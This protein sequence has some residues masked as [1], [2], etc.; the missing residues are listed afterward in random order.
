MAKYTASVSFYC[1]HR[2]SE[3]FWWKCDSLEHIEHTVGQK[4]IRG[5]C[6]RSS[7]RS[8][9]RQKLLILKILLRARGALTFFRFFPFFLRT[10]L[11]NQRAIYIL[12]P[13]SAVCFML[14]EALS[15]SLQTE[16]TSILFTIVEQEHK[17]QA[18]ITQS[19]SNWPFTF[20]KN[21]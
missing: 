6:C 15:V 12:D 2:C 16:V 8:F 1:N 21:L 3:V 13:F 4:K 19:A 18:K 5:L 9:Y 10:L 20:V 7:L 17:I 14:P 11:H